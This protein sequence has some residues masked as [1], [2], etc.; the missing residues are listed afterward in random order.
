MKSYHRGA[1]IGTL[2]GGLCGL[3]IAV[4][5]AAFAAPGGPLGKQW[6]PEKME[7]HMNEVIE[8]LDLSAAQDAQIRTIM[9]DALTQM[10][11][12]K[13]MPRGE[14]KFEAMRDL[15]FTT[16]DQIHANLTCDQ[17]EQL[18]LLT[19]EHRAERMRQRFEQYQAEQS[20]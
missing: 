15:R 1:I 3:V 11:E 12:I 14:E 13:D 20:E 19:R 2:V 16:E 8:Q 4:T 6:N 5:A 17:R 18:R 10:T 9:Q 7:R